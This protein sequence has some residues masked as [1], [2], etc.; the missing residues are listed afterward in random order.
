M[1]TLSKEQINFHTANDSSH[2]EEFRTSPLESEQQQQSHV[3]WSLP[4][5]DIRKIKST[6]KS[7]ERFEVKSGY[8]MGG[9]PKF[10]DPLP[11]GPTA[12]EETGFWEKEVERLV[13]IANSPGSLRLHG[14]EDWFGKADRH[15]Y[16]RLHKIAIQLQDALDI[17]IHDN[18][19]LLI[20]NMPEQA[21][22]QTYNI[23]HN[24]LL[25]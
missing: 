25:R 1:A 5:L 12:V 7:H 2:T 16:T 18:E 8:V 6:L 11:Y 4:S 17:C 19:L 24:R 23:A 15:G 22:R 9:L 13:K 20:E 10:D 3:E 14:D 21:D